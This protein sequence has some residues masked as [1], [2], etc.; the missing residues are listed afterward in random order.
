MPLIVL[1]KWNGFE[2]MTDEKHLEIQEFLYYATLYN[3]M[4]D[5]KDKIL[6]G[7]FL[8]EEDRESPNSS[9]V[10]HGVKTMKKPIPVLEARLPGYTSLSVHLG[11]ESILLDDLRAVNEQLE[12]QGFGKEYYPLTRTYSRQPSLDIYYFSEFPKKRIS[13]MSVTYSGLCRGNN[14]RRAEIYL[15]VLDQMRTNVGAFSN[16]VF[17]E[18][19]GRDLYYL[20][21]IDG[22]G[23][24]LYLGDLKNNRYPGLQKVE[25]ARRDLSIEE[26][27]KLGV[28]QYFQ[29]DKSPS[30][31]ELYDLFLL[32][33]L[34][35]KK[36]LDSISNTFKI[37][38]VPKKDRY[39]VIL[40]QARQMYGDNP[41]EKEKFEELLSSVIKDVAY[42]E[43]AKREKDVFSGFV[44]SKTLPPIVN[45]KLYEEMQKCLDPEARMILIFGIYNERG[46]VTPEQ[47]RE[48][49]SKEVQSKKAGLKESREMFLDLVK[50]SDPQNGEY[51]MEM[52]DILLQIQ[53]TP[54]SSF[55]Q[56][57]M[58]ELLKESYSFF[59]MVMEDAGGDSSLENFSRLLKSSTYG[60][61][62]GIASDVLE[63]KGVSYVE[64]STEMEENGNDEVPP[65]VPKPS[66]PEEPGESGR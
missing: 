66:D 60:E 20:A 26:R 27:Q 17:P 32:G 3:E 22:F 29:Y 54:K 15:S 34:L 10:D 11:A 6:F 46:R 65:K 64:Q 59:Q 12:P 24:G 61:L 50:R 41:E 28:L 31:K 8:E 7:I 1:K 49:Q 43:D 55:D 57:T 36:N 47:Y 5:E 33:E 16:L 37:D 63:E 56:E 25:E 45:E 13:R 9:E 62:L 4:A 30:M 18:A 40:E 23:R 2:K 52:L 58:S 42:E 38:G 48:S 19:N 14:S 44:S 39:G 53:D 35:K 51:L 21:D